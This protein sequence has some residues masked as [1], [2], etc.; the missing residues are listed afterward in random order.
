V[1]MERPSRLP[2]RAA[3]GVAVGFH[4]HRRELVQ[5]FVADLRRFGLPV[6][7]LVP[8]PLALA[9]YAEL[10]W[11]TRGRRLVIEVQRT[12]TDLLWSSE[13]GPRWRSVP[14]GCGA[15]AESDG[16][17]ASPAEIERL[18]NRILAEH[19]LAHRALFGAHDGTPLEKVVLLGDSEQPEPLKRALQERLGVE[20]VLPHTARH[21]VVSERATG[22]SGHRVLSF[23]TALG[24]AIA[25][26][27][28]RGEPDSLVSPPPVRRAARRLPVLSASLLVIALGL[29]ATRI[30]A[31][32][33]GRDLDLRRKR[34]DE[35]VH[36]SAAGDW[37]ESRVA[38]QSAAE[39]SRRLLATAAALQR[40]VGFPSRLLQAL[41]DPAVFFKLV[42]FELAPLPDRDEATLTFEVANG[43]VGAAARIEEHLNQRAGVT[44]VGIETTPSQDGPLRVT[45][46][47]AVHG[48]EAGS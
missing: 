5:T 17:A 35:S 9:R 3:R 21:L 37:E 41:S 14:F 15:L 16:G 48:P 44:V 20:V 31:E 4:A 39:E 47:A 33:Q 42:S 7:A 28:P 26:L 27:S 38:A 25:A 19:Q 24:L 46:R 13:H 6:D 43:L 8:G 36:W 29:L 12:R 11:P 1:R 45:L 40:E 10:E 18:A 22:A 2:A 30:V 23:G 32:Q 34:F